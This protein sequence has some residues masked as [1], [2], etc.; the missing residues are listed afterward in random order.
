[1]EQPKCP[2]TEECIKKR[3]YIYTIEYYSATKRNE[4]MAFLATW[5]DLEIIMLGGVSQ[6][7]RHQHKMLSLTSGNGKKDIVN[8]FAEHIQTHRL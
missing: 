3:W 2:S 6:T 4:I 8:F 7:M 1:M 5:V